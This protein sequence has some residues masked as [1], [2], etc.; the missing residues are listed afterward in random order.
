MLLLLLELELLVELLL[1]LLLLLT[2]LVLVRPSLI[3]WRRRSRS[4]CPRCSPA[5]RA[6]SRP[7]RYHCGSLPLLLL[8][9]PQVNPC[10]VLILLY[11]L[12]PGRPSRLPGAYEDLRNS[13]HDGRPGPGRDSTRATA[14]GGAGCGAGA[15]P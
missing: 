14:G 7:S 10:L 12:L 3:S 11:F 13:G 6:T 1:L 4:S 5:A 9:I 8:L 15:E 2:L